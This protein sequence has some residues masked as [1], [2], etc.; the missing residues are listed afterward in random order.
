[1]FE[2]EPAPS[3]KAARSLAVVERKELAQ[4][5]AGH[6]VAAWCEGYAETHDAKPTVRQI[7]QVGRES[8]QLFESGNAPERVIRAARLAGARGVAMVERE[9]NSM[10]KRRDVVQPSAPAAAP[11]QSTTDARV[12]QG[13]ALAAKY[14][15][16]EAG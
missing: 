3:V 12:Q 4:A 11:R 9:H 5:N 15:D 8:R 13:L 16:L 10:A 7:G 14:A 2:V 6:A 1:M